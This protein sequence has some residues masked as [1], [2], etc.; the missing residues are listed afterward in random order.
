MV[1]LRDASFG[2]QLYVEMC[3]S[4]SDAFLFQLQQEH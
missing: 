3:K 4:H 2:I 1:Y